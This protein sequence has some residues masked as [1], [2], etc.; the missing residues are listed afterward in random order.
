MLI[1]VINAGKDNTK[2]PFE[3]APSQLR[4]QLPGGALLNVST[5]TALIREQESKLP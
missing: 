2:G 1:L 4:L 3:T 5:E